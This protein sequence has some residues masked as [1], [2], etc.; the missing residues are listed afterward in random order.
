MKQT[1]IGLV[2]LLA[3]SLSAQSTETIIELLRS[4]LQS[5][6]KAVVAESMELTSEQSDKFWPIYNEFQFEVTKLGDKK[7]A[8]IKEYAE[9]YDQLTNEVAENLID[10]SFDLEEDRL[11][12]NKKYYKKVSKA[13]DAKHAGKFIQ[14]L[15][16][17]NMLIDIQLSAEIPLLPTAK[18]QTIKK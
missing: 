2:V 3:S 13:L 14:L 7:I 1:I 16:R 9:N 12:L 15:N 6:K 18:D 4:D 11:S 8:I 10:Q 5:N 17:M